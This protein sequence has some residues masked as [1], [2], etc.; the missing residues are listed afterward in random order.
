[1][2]KAVER[3][4]GAITVAYIPPPAYQSDDVFYEGRKRGAQYETQSVCGCGTPYP[5]EVERIVGRKKH[6]D[7]DWR[8]SGAKCPPTT[9]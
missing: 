8:K 6:D 5:R 7:S 1:M 9:S 2:L 3:V 4:V